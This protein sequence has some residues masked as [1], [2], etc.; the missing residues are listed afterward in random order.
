MHPRIDFLPHPF[1]E[2]IING[3]QSKTFHKK[4]NPTTNHPHT[5]DKVIIRV[6]RIHP[7]GTLMNFGAGITDMTLTIQA[8]F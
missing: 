1:G 8:G 6:I 3:Y 2:V 7:L 5:R 4:K